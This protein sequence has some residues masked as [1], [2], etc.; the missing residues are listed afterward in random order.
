MFL[1]TF[2]KYCHI[3][4]MKNEYFELMPVRRL[5]DGRVCKVYPFHISLEGL[6][7]GILCRDS[8]DFDSTVKIIAVCCFRKNAILVMYA[9]VSNHAHCV[10]LASSQ[11][12]A[13]ACANEI[14]RMVSMYQREKYSK[15]EMM[16]GV[17]AKAIII[18]DVRY[19]RNALAYD[20]RNAMD[21]G[22]SCVQNYKWTGYRG[23]FCEGKCPGVRKVRE[24]SKRE[25]RSIMHTHENL[26][27][28]NWLLNADNELEP[29]SI[30]DW[31]Y[32]EGAFRNDQA[33][34]LRLIGA[35]NTAEMNEG[36]IVAPR[37]KRNDQEFLASVNEKSRLWF[38][39]DVEHLSMQKKAH[40]INYAIHSFKTDPYQVARTFEMER[41]AV[42]AIMGRKKMAGQ[43]KSEAT[44]GQVRPEGGVPGPENNHT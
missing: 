4:H 31:R 24:L 9:V 40:L 1:G 25:K 2:G 6:E 12:E 38:G 14:K 8:E 18:E 10:V 26:S 41:D 11:K 42:L 36:L 22:A 32:L 34:F 43:P 44:P 23:M 17:D 15:V 30:C 28:V 13:D 3:R 7:S 21:N 27:D 29:A 16:S 37:R 35:V 19:V 33:F 20:V 39:V 5:P